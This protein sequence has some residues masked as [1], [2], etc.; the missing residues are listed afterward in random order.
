M[1]LV[2]LCGIELKKPALSKYPLLYLHGNKLQEI[3][4]QDGIFQTLLELL[5]ESMYIYLHQ[6][7]RR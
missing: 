3:L 7:D 2:T 6:Q 4:K 5:M 1:K